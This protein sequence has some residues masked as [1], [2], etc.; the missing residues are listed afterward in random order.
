MIESSLNRIL[1]VD[2]EK[3]IRELLFDFLSRQNYRVNTACDGVEAAAILRQKEFDLIVTDLAM[4]N[5]DGFELI[6]E[7]SAIQPLTTIIV[8]SGQGTFENAIQAVRDGAYDFVAK[9]VMDFESFKISIER[10]LE[11]KSLLQQKE[12]YQRNLETMV[13]EQTEELAEKNVLLKD[14]ALKLESVSVSVITS[15]LTALEEKDRY[16]AGHSRRVTHYAVETAR[17]MG[18]TGSDLWVIQTAG[19]LHDMGKLVIDVDY[20]NKPGPLTDD[21]WRMMKE[22]PAIADRFLAPLPF[23]ENVRPIVQHHHERRDGS[24]YPDGLSGDE[25]DHLTQIMAV[26]DSYDAMTSRRSYREPM[27]K[28][29]AV[30]ELRRCK[31]KFFLPEIVEALIDIIDNEPLEDS[32]TTPIRQTNL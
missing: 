14:Y 15:L 28:E 4:P 22:H 11:R 26:A 30:A 10:A 31:E 5:M 20:V 18:L 1:V 19:Q 2:D 12:N 3:A 27:P 6:K 23:L 9:P 25:I 29:D 8:L 21:E 16:T 7:A 17:Q 32:D 24:G 13:A